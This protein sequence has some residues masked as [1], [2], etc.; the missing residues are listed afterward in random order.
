MHQG[1]QKDRL[2]SVPRRLRGDTTILPHPRS[3]RVKWADTKMMG[4]MTFRNFHCWRAGRAQKSRDISERSK[5]SPAWSSTGGHS[6]KREREAGG[7][8]SK[9]QVPRQCQHLAKGADNGQAA[10]AWPCPEGLLV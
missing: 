1:L 3:S 4:K 2:G 9:G 5:G 7:S 8:N 10:K 6:G